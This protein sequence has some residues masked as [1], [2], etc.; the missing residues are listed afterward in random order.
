MAAVND[1]PRQYK[2]P[3][4]GNLEGIKNFT[5]EWVAE[6]KIHGANLSF[7]INYETS[8]ITA[9]RR[10]D[11][12]KED[13]KFYDY[14]VILEKY[15]DNILDLC[16]GLVPQLPLTEQ[17]E[18]IIIYGEL[19]GGKPPVQ[20]GVF[21]SD[22]YEFI[23][24]DIATA[25]G[26]KKKW[27]E[28]EYS[29]MLFLDNGFHIIPIVARGSFKEVASTSTVF[30][31]LV[32]AMLSIDTDNTGSDNTDNTCSSDNT[33]TNGKSNYAEGFVMRPVENI[34]DTY[35]RRVLFKV[36]NPAF[37]EVKKKST[38]GNLKENS[39]SIS[40]NEELFNDVITYINQNR[41]DSVKSKLLETDLKN[42]KLLAGS[43]CSDIVKDYPWTEEFKESREFKKL[44][45]L[46]FKECLDFVVSAIQNA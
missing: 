22:N 24:F 14:K 43:L 36:K 10:N 35:G 33:D 23:P 18:T 25:V 21:Y 38:S 45:V 19:C 16:E 27:L 37:G 29:R 11:F 2:Y 26:D 39:A 41:L 28:W 13:D 40:L 17:I 20:T 30:N 12:L 31:S 44:K 46:L 6:E 34:Y 7:H 4:I 15:T 3:S 42:I 1:K 8:Q 9:A 5:G 32:P